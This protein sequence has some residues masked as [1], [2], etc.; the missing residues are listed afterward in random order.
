MTAGCPGCTLRACPALS[1]RQPN[2]YDVGLAL[3]QCWIWAG[4]VCKL[5]FELLLRARLPCNSRLQGWASTLPLRGS[6]LLSCRRFLLAITHLSRVVLWPPSA[7]NVTEGQAAS[8][9]HISTP[10]T[11]RPLIEGGL[12]MRFAPKFGR[13]QRRVPIAAAVDAN[14]Y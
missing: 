6:A 8:S 12:C 14:G 3:R 2:V 5:C 9:I 11:T 4:V 7:M 10:S 13:D 1:Q